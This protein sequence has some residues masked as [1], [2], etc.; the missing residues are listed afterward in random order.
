ME[1]LAIHGICKLAKKYQVE[2]ILCRVAD[3]LKANWPTGLRE[4]VAAQSAFTGDVDYIASN[5]H[6][7]WERV[8]HD[9]PEP[10]LSIR[11]AKEVGELSVLSAAFYRLAISAPSIDWIKTL[12][13]R[14]AGTLSARW[15][16]LEKED[17]VRYNAG[18]DE[19]FDR[20][21]RFFPNEYHET[22]KE[23][24]SKC[25][26]EDKCRMVVHDL[27]AF[28]DKQVTADF[29][30]QPDVIRQM[31]ELR[32]EADDL[33]FCFSCG[34]ALGIT[35]YNYMNKIWD[36]LPAIFGLTDPH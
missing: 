7:I 11:L 27:C 23:L 1:K 29:A 28:H 34:D 26:N 14:K 31:L 15:D 17:W 2:S 3:H 5:S 32:T 4:Y 8:E 6:D 13:V 20:S 21:R 22:L 12:R 35:I 30:R 19:L 25:R 36:D 16:L 24:G 9:Y 10:A 33:D 18:K